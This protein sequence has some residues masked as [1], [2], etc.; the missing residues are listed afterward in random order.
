MFRHKP[1]VEGEIPDF[2]GFLVYLKQ[3][4]PDLHGR[5]ERELRRALVAD[6]AMFA[7]FVGTIMSGFGLFSSMATS[8]L[9]IPFIAGLVS[10]F[11][12]IA[13]MLALSVAGR[14]A[15][16]AAV[17]IESEIVVEYHRTGGWV[18]GG[19]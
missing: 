18:D 15:H 6:V 9:S 11:A 12:F 10:F 8:T 14:K 13:A 16:A 2:K 19:H 1:Q 5:Y 3:V 17:R 7:C 4:N